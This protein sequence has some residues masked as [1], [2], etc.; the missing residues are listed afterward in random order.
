MSLLRRIEKS[1]DQR[2]RSMFSGGDDEPGAREAVELYRDALDQIASRATAG[3]RGDRIFPF[4]LITI[5]F[6]A[7]DAERKAVLETLFDPGQFGDDV[8]A[9]LK[10]ERI[11]PPA[12]LTVSVKYPEDALVEMR[13][14]CERA[15]TEPVPVV[16]H[17]VP[18]AVVVELH[19]ARLLTITGVSSSPEFL[20][21]RPRINLGRAA[22]I[23]DALGRTIRRNELFFPEQAH[24]ANPSVS[25]SHAHIA[26]DASSGDWRIFDDGSSIG[27]TLFRQGR[28]IDVPPHASRGVALR[29]GDEIYLGQV[30]LQFEP[31]V[32]INNARG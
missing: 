6:R 29:P 21:E 4:N 7:E 12:D 30:R 2:L 13:V 32:P 22:E 10:E 28:R 25:R 26:F 1:L 23:T 24:E 20:L 9:T 5:E 19:P 15:K 14:I 8:Q 16:T 17:V 3:K 27:T 31:G 18:A 11:T